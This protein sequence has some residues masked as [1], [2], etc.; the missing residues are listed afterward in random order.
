MTVTISPTDTG[1]A[2]F[3]GFLIALSTSLHLYLKGRVTGMSGIFWSLITFE[4]PSFI[5]KISLLS[6]SLIVSAIF[7]LTTQP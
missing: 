2:I 6:G 7:F 5:W 3:G 1:F 4:L